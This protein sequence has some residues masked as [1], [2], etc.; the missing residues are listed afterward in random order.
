MT[1]NL[2]PE[3]HY[4]FSL[5]F[6]KQQYETQVLKYKDTKETLRLRDDIIARIKLDMARQLTSFP[7]DWELQFTA[8]IFVMWMETHQQ[9]E[10][11]IKTI[12]LLYCLEKRGYMIC[13]F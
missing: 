4:E 6:L 3:Q 10:E 9:A 11:D 8:S 12:Y 13:V 5:N 1:F 2:S 7:L